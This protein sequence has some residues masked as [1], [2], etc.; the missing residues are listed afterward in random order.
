MEKI[1][2]L[3]FGGQYC[4]LI[5]RR[6]REL[7]VCAEV[8][9]ANISLSALNNPSVKGVILSG[10]ASSVF[11]KKAPSFNKKIISLA[12]PILGICYGHQLLAHLSGGKVTSGKSGEY[13]LTKLII[14]KNEE[15]LSHLGNSKNVWM[16]HQDII[17]K[18]PAGF[19]SLAST[20]HSKFA[21]FTNKKSNIFGLQ[22]HPEVNHTEQGTQ[23]LKNFVSTICKCKKKWISNL[24]VENLIQETKEVIGVN[25]AII[26]L[27]GG[28][29]SSVA[30]A[31]VSSAI[32]R[33]LVAVYVDTGLMR[34][35]ETK[36]IQKTFLKK[37]LNLKIIKASK[38]F[39]KALKK[40]TSPEKKRKIIGRLFVD[41]FSAIAKKEGATFLI[42]G[43]I[44]SDRIES[45][46]SKHSS[47][48][49]SHHNVGGLPKNLK[50]KLYEPL[51]DLYK[52][53]VRN[54]AKILGIAKEITL[55]QV[56]PGPG[57][58]VRIIGEVTPKRVIIVRQASNI[59][60]E[61]LR[62]KK[63]WKSIWMSFAVLY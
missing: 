37:K 51:K 14:Q 35:G 33:Q 23:I 26:G 5:A 38:Q 53:E 58:A 19:I 13:G 9:P 8:V 20:E 25:K 62:E 1:I 47:K 48:I 40:V 12:V 6:I 50:M 46:L 17:T 55:Q 3:D 41:I 54:I 10:G 4:H 32:S 44:Y 27:S 49:K 31:L 16:N 56:F 2:I 15:I 52:D 36:F 24:V 57:L 59:I 22:F 61:E 63:I 18:L 29:D 60:E 34:E 42:Q 7:G 11:D 43:T 45:G 21:V 39:F 28:V 30:A